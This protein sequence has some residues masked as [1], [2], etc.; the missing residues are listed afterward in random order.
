MLHPHA[1]VFGMVEFVGILLF[2]TFKWNVRYFMRAIYVVEILQPRSIP[3]SPKRTRPTAVESE[4]SVGF[5]RNAQYFMHA[6]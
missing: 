5:K 2:G 1:W 6:I 4:V 3:Y